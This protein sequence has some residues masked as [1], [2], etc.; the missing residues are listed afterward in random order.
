MNRP[1]G[2]MKVNILIPVI[3]V[4]FILGF[5]CAGIRLI[6]D[7][8]MAISEYGTWLS[9][10]LFERLHEAGVF[11]ILLVCAMVAIGGIIL[12]MVLSCRIVFTRQAYTR[13]YRISE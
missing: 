9:K 11:Q 7:R 10:P 2:K 3:I 5:I 12:N 6:S 13:Q 8:A 1:K 4:P